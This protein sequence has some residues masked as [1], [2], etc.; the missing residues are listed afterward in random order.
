MAQFA[1]R[2]CNPTMLAAALKRIDTELKDVKVGPWRGPL[3]A[4]LAQGMCGEQSIALFQP[5]S[6]RALWPDPFDDFP[7][8]LDHAINPAG[9]IGEVGDT[10]W[11]LWDFEE[12]NYIVFQ[13]VHK[14]R[15]VVTELSGNNGVISG[16]KL[17]VAV[18]TC[19]DANPFA[20]E[21]F[22][23]FDVNVQ[24]VE[25]MVNA[26]DNGDK[27]MGTARPVTVLGVA[28][29]FDFVIVETT[30]CEDA[31]PSGSGSGSDEESGP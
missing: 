19:D 12:N 7:E 25:V 14:L 9:M 6:V 10:V 4:T 16:S 8:N 20:F 31:E 23:G 30:D 22:P 26:Y 1:K 21:V 11:L 18:Q 17:N 15:Q 27:I 24:T 13:V 2:I 28:G 29:E 3:K 5:A